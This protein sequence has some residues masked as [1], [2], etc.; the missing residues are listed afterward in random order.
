MVADFMAKPHQG[1]EFR[2]FRDNIMGRVRSTQTNKD[3]IKVVER[4]SRKLIKKASKMTGR[5]HVKLVTQ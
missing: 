3:V 4:T 1:W 2:N 5:N